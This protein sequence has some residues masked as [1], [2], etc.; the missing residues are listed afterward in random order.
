MKDFHKKEKPLQGISGW[1]GGATGLRMAG[2]RA[3]P[4]Y[5]DPGQQEY[6]TAGTYTWVGG[7]NT[8]TVSMVVVSGGGGGDVSAYQQTDRGGGGGGGLRYKNNVEIAGGENYTIV[9]GSGGVT[10][11]R[12]SYTDGG[13]SYVRDSSGTDL[14]RVSGGLRKYL[15][16]AGENG[17]GG[18]SY[19]TN[20]G[21]GGGNGGGGRVA[22]GRGGGGGAAGYSGDGGQGGGYA[23]G[24]DVPGAGSGGGGG[25]GGGG[26]SDYSSEGHGSGGG[27][28]GI[29]GEGSSGDAGANRACSAYGPNPRGRQGGYGSGGDTGSRGT[30]A[31]SCAAD[32]VAGAGLG[33]GGGAGCQQSVSTT[34]YYPG[35]G[36]AIRLIWPGDARSFPSTRTADE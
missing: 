6:T 27:G 13:D 29:W 7:K 3:G 36:G 24:H 17:A 28:V 4:T 10:A 15:N 11:A 16:T 26:R 32:N 30:S 23:A 35:G 33:F 22:G 9:V 18:G 1:G 12:P 19:G 8:L 14:C 34:T 20:V 5:D 31:N 25:G 21:D 2:G